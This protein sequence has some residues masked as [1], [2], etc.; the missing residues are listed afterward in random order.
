MSC[1]RACTSHYHNT[2][3]TYIR[4][5]YLTRIPFSYDLKWFLRGSQVLAILDHLQLATWPFLLGKHE[6]TVNKMCTYCGP[7]WSHVLKVTWSFR[8]LCLMMV[9]EG[10]GAV[11]NWANKWL[12]YSECGPTDNETNSVGFNHH[13]VHVLSLERYLIRTQLWEEEESQ[14]RCTNHIHPGKHHA[15]LTSSLAFIITTLISALAFLQ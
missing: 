15:G 7:I 9:R 11:V 13:L 1:L 6:N 12:L 2:Q 3:V 5:T 10:M 4:I 14:V 8:H